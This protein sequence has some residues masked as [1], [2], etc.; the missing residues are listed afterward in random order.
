M[1]TAALQAIADLSFRTK[2]ES[3][4]VV[5]AVAGASLWWVTRDPPPVREVVTAAPMVRQA[6]QSV[7]AERAPDAHPPKPVHILPK[8]STEE[9]RGTVI[10]AQAPSASSVEIDFSLVREKDNGRR[11]IFSSPDGQ[12]TG[13]VD[14]PIEPGLIPPPP[15]KWAAGLAYSTEREVGIWLERDIG[16]LRLGAEVAKGAGSPRAELRV[17]VT[18]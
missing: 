13:A 14:I 7:I 9:R 2:I 11:M 10:A 5:V 12:I 15:H 1:I 4:V 18:F 17:G 16:R 8:G 3:L 6:D